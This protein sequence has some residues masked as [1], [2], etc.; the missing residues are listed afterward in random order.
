MHKH[1]QKYTH[2][3][4]HSHTYRPDAGTNGSSQYLNNDL[5]CWSTLS[6]TWRKI[7]EIIIQGLRRENI[8]FECINISVL[9][10]NVNFALSQMLTYISCY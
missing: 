8:G 9:K 4:I 10:E 7:V 6:L 3:S 1:T 2:V 5:V